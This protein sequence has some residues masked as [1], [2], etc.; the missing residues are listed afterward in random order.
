MLASVTRRP[1]AR[2]RARAGVGSPGSECRPTHG[3]C[4][5]FF[6]TFFPS[7]NT[8]PSEKRSLKLQFLLGWAVRV[9]ER[10]AWSLG[11][12]WWR[13]GARAAAQGPS[14]AQQCQGHH[15]P[16]VVQGTAGHGA[17]DHRLAPHGRTSLRQ[18]R[19]SRWL[20]MLVT[21]CLSEAGLYVVIKDS[22][23]HSHPK[24]LAFT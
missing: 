14:V 22:G 23:H 7:V 12:G 2:L 5:F 18:H 20:H 16:G 15:S 17:E 3:G 4:S 13:N 21:E 9:P 24:K 19:S 1:L 6:V 11:S 8:Q 10:P